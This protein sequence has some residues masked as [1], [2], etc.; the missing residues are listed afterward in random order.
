MNK[1]EL[2]DKLFR[3]VAT[4][5]C[6]EDLLIEQPETCLKKSSMVKN[7]CETCWLEQ[8]EKHEF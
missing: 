3:I 6:P 1:D 2:C 8:I 7:P 5:C 4:R